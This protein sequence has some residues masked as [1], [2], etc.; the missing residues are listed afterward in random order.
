MAQSP[1]VRFGLSSPEAYVIAIDSC[2]PNEVSKRFLSFSFS[3][4][5]EFADSETEMLIRTRWTRS[6]YHP[7]ARRSLAMATSSPPGPLEKSIR[8][9]VGH[10]AQ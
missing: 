4:V 7:I 1:F 9:K 10:A 8:D 6:I 5:L 3:P 2:G